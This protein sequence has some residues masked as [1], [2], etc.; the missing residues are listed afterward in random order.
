MM[1]SP[2]LRSLSSPPFLFFCCLLLLQLPICRSIYCDEDDCYDLLGVSQ[3]AN[4]SE[5][6]KAYYKL[7]LKHHP[8]KNPDPESRKLFVKI[9]NA[10]EILKDEATREQYDYAIAHPEEAV[11]MVKKTPAY[12]N[13]LKA[14]ELE[15]SGGVTNKKKGLKQIDNGDVVAVPAELMA[16]G[17]TTPCP[18][19]PASE[20]VSRFRECAPRVMLLKVGGFGHLAFCRIAQP[21]I[22]TRF[23]AEDAIQCLF[24]GVLTNLGSLRELHGLRKCDDEAVVVIKAYK[25]IRGRS[26]YPHS[27][28]LSHLFGSFAFVLFDMNSSSILVASDVDGGVPLFWGI[29]SDGCLAFSDHLELLKG[30]CGKSLAPFPPGCFYS[31]TLGGLKSYRSP[32]DRV[33][34]VLENEEEVCGVT[35]KV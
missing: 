28:M 35:F 14:L 26:P 11:T 20:L 21:P 23:A 25:V 13:R 9:A 18:R 7:S 1:V 8:D 31:N 4:A 2:A 32:G 29:T 34:A 10:Y 15:R 3:S 12:K 17:S 24:K 6:K 33:I 19:T 5:I 27:L 30:S 22:H 16:V